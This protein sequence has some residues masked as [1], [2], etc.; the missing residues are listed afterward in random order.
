MSK[1]EWGTRYGKMQ[2]TIKGTPRAHW[3]YWVRQE[4]TY[5]FTA[6]FYGYGQ[7]IPYRET[8]RTIREAR[9]YCEKKDAEAII[10]TAM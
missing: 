4:G 9:A 5:N 2:I 1:L 3:Y 7:E 10:I 6:G 8:F